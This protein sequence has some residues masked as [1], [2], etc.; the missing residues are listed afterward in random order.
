MAFL[1]G[2]PS[3]RPW[4]MAEPDAS[5]F[6]TLTPQPTHTPGGP[7]HNAE[8]TRSRPT[9]TPDAEPRPTPELRSFRLREVESDDQIWVSTSDPTARRRLSD[10]SPEQSAWACGAVRP[11]PEMEW[12]FR[13]DG[14]QLT[15][16]RSV[17]DTAQTT[18]RRIAADV[19]LAAS[20]GRAWCIHANGVLDERSG[21]PPKGGSATFQNW[22]PLLMNRH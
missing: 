2:D 15:L 8:P 14:R 13:L 7:T 18:I 4:F 20:A 5:P 21:P 22:L 3:A 19:A 1:K 9:G 16:L 11:D 17:P 10:L 6:P 12:G